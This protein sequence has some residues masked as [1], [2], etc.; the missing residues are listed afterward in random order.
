VH[1]FDE[2]IFSGFN[3]PRL[4]LPYSSIEEVHFDRTT[5]DGGFNLKIVCR[6]LFYKTK[7]SHEV[8]FLDMDQ[9]DC[10]KALVIIREGMAGQGE[11]KVYAAE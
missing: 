3:H 1:F 10:E 6:E 11:V 4:F 5:D 9:A 2:G 7:K 8:V